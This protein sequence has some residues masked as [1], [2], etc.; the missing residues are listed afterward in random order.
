[1]AYASSPENA[2]A[3]ADADATDI[4]PAP[5]GVVWSPTVDLFCRGRYKKNL[6]SNRCFSLLFFERGTFPHASQPSWRSAR[7]TR[8]TPTRPR[9]PSES[10]PPRISNG[11]TG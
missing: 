8:S 7:R 4:A 10:L 11:E 5:V 6:A 9:C 2:G 1:M 3:D